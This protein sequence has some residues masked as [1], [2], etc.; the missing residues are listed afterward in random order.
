MARSGRHHPRGMPMCAC[1]TF[2][3]S[4]LLALTCPSLTQEPKETTLKPTLIFSGSH[5]VI[6][7]ERFAVVTGEAG[8][9]DLWEQH[10]GKESDPPFTERDQELSIDF[11]THYVVAVFTGTD[12][13]L[14]VTTF[15][16]G[17]EI[18]I[19][20]TAR[21]YQTEGRPPEDKRTAHQKA[22]DAAGADYCF[23]VLPKPIKTIVVERDV[24]R[25]LDYPPLW[26]EI[27]RFPVPQGKK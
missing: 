23:V 20:F 26:Q 7:K 3:L 14:F 19:R 17:D 16:R 27:A 24:R 25:R 21:G 18:L 11:D 6:R 15:A 10:R 12:A 5:S 22:K 13:C 9:K 4:A 1:V 2:G 8:W